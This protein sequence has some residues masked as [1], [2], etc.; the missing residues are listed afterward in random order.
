[1][2]IKLDTP[3]IGVCST[4]YGDKICR[5][6]KRRFDEVI[7]WLSYSAEDKQRVYDRLNDHMVAIVGQYITVKDA[8]VVRATLDRYSI[9][10]REDQDP[11]TWALHLL[12]FAGNKVVSAAEVGLV[13]HAPYDTLPLDQLCNTIDKQL[14]AYSVE[15]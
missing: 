2:A 11:L 6:C 9:R 8:D 10:Y 4:V 13:V 3:C 14:Y 5:G 15:F 12:M 1:M 7:N